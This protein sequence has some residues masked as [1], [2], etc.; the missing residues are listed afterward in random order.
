MPYTYKRGTD[1]TENEISILNPHGGGMAQILFWHDEPE[2]VADAEQTAQLIVDALNAHAMNQQL[3][4]ALTLIGN[5][6]RVQCNLNSTATREERNRFISSVF[7]AW[8]G[9]IVPVMES[10]VL[11]YA[12]NALTVNVKNIL[13]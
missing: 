2:D 7:D 5:A 10:G 4:K 12:D 9:V 13:Q 1:G 3:L 11:G 6:C 8:N